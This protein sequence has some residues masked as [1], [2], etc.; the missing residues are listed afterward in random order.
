VGDQGGPSVEAVEDVSAEDDG[1]GGRAPRCACPAVGGTE[2]DGDMASA[3]SHHYC[4]GASGPLTGFSD[5][6]VQALSTCHP[7]GAA[8]TMGRRRWPW[9]FSLASEGEPRDIH[10]IGVEPASGV[11]IIHAE[12]EGSH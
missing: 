8:A 1:W 3:D 7:S 4:T 9:L 11:V 5:D 2:A 6:D 10:V 12:D